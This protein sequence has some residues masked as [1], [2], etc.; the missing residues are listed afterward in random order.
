MLLNNN[1]LLD[2][3][4]YSHQHNFFNRQFMF[5]QY[6]YATCFDHNFYHYKALN[7]HITSNQTH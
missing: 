7:E 2:Y 4:Y 1:K 6:S 5:Y 3:L